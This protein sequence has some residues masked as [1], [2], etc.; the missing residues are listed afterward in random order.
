M[1]RCVA[2][3]S[4]RAYGIIAV[5]GDTIERDEDTEAHLLIDAPGCWEIVGDEPA[6]AEPA[7][8]ARSIDEPPTDRMLRPTPRRG[9]PPT[10]KGA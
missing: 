4:N 1:L 10:R 2:R 6:A 3:Y 5:P 8:D 7:D 9:R